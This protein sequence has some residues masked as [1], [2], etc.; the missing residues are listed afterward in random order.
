MADGVEPPDAIS[1]DGTVNLDWQSDYAGYEQLVIRNASGERFAAYPVVEGQSWS[2]S[3][4]SDGTYHIEL[5]G[6]NETKTIST[7]Q[8]DHYSLRS[9]LSLFGAGLLLFGYLIFTLKRGTASHD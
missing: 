7:L 4:L 2:L 9:A 6:G 8:V 5:S 3:G 1:K